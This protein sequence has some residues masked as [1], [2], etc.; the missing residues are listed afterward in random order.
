MEINLQNLMQ[1]ISV[2]TSVLYIFMDLSL[3]VSVFEDI[4]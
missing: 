3:E 2:G 1:N 4:F